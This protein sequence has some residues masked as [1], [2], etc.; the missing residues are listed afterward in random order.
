MAK[1]SAPLR[2]VLVQ[3][4]DDARPVRQ[5]ELLRRVVSAKT[6]FLCFR[7]CVRFIRSGKV[8]D[9]KLVYGSTR[10]R[11]SVESILRKLS[12]V[13]CRIDR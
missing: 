5:D 10:V 9:G 8:V 11:G 12:S 6:S 13:V 3:V 7:L 1:Q 4:L 2:G